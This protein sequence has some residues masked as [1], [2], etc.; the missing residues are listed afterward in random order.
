MTRAPPVP[1][2]SGSN[3]VLVAFV[4]AVLHF[5]GPYPLGIS[6]HFFYAHQLHFIVFFHFPGSK[7]KKKKSLFYWFGDVCVRGA[8]WL[9]LLKHSEQ[10]QRSRVSYVQLLLSSLPCELLVFTNAC[11]ASL[12]VLCTKLPSLLAI[13][14][15]SR[16]PHVLVGLH[17]SEQVAFLHVL[18]LSPYL[19]LRAVSELTLQ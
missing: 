11:V 17:L 3:L 4:T 10:T 13:R 14:Y 1:T 9:C 12:P 18:A 16:F 2:V 7:K 15:Q 6:K 5:C 19:L 8:C